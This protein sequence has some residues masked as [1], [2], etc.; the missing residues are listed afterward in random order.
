M[1]KYRVKTSQ[2]LEDGSEEEVVVAEVVSLELAQAVKQYINQ[3]VA[4][5]NE[6]V[7]NA[8]TPQVLICRLDE[9]VVEK[10]I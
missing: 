1:M 10:G 7:W 3:T 6:Y 2:L 5:A 9:T 8:T 4:E